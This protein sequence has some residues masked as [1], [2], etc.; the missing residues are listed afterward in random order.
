M[1]F[2]TPLKK[3]YRR[4]YDDY[5]RY[6]HGGS[7][8]GDSSPTTPPEEFGRENILRAKEDVCLP[9]DDGFLD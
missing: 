5:H 7:V 9:V 6:R 4:G 1:A 8:Y 2:T 3:A